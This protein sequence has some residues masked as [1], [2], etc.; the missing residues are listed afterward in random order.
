[1]SSSS[2]DFSLT[3]DAICTIGTNKALIQ[4]DLEY[5]PEWLLL[6]FGAI[7]AMAL[8]LRDNVEEG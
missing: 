7:L 2:V 5:I 4:L 3:I 8:Q 1:M 6:L